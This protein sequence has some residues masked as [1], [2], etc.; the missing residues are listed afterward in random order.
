MPSRSRWRGCLIASRQ[1]SRNACLATEGEAAAVALLN[2]PARL[3]L[4][5]RNRPFL[6]ILY[7][8]AP[9]ASVCL[10]MQAQTLD[11]LLAFAYPEVLKIESGQ[12][13][14]SKHRN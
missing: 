7:L 8:R 1:R 6:D 13:R 10:A 12:M 5:A 3:T 4:R 11:P 9:S 14:Q 2:L